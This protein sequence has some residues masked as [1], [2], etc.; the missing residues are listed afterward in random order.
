MRN[1]D[2]I[3]TVENG[4]FIHRLYYDRFDNP[5]I[6]KSWSGLFENE[7]YEDKLKNPYY[8]FG[9]NNNLTEDNIIF[10]TFI[11]QIL[12]DK[13]SFGIPCYYRDEAKAILKKDFDFIA[14]EYDLEY[15][16]CE[17]H[18]AEPKDNGFVK[19]RSCIPIRPEPSEWQKKHKDLAGLFQVE[20][21]SDVIGLELATFGDATSEI[22]F[23]GLNTNDKNFLIQKLSTTKRPDLTDILEQE[24]IFIDLLIGQDMGYWTCL[25]V[26]SKTDIS[27]LIKNITTD[28]YNKCKLY[29]EN[30]DGIKTIDEFINEMKK[31][32]GC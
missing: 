11:W 10:S 12:K 23:F 3:K 1:I 4:L 17:I 6:E 2:F 24:D 22:S 18:M 20:S 25:S 5:I 15:D 7:P 21:Y 8:N 28:I 29:E 26:Y 32:N 14:W 30:I 13:K 31:I 16:E 9:I 27:S 19:G